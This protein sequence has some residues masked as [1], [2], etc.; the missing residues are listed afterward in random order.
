MSR[1]T[2]CRAW[3]AVLALVVAA[4]LITQTVLL[5]N[6]GTDVNTASGEGSWYP[7]PFLNAHLHGYGVAVRNT[8]AV[9]VLALV[10]IGIWRLADRRL[11]T[12]TR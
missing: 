3:Y 7:Y 4:S 9:V 5:V 11:P 2:A 1:E 10:I 8:A 6:S 12:V